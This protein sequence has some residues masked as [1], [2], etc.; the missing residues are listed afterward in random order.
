MY[1][2]LRPLNLHLQNA[3]LQ[4]TFHLVFTSC[5]ETIKIHIV[6]MEAQK[7]LKTPRVKS[8]IIFSKSKGLNSHTYLMTLSL[9]I[10]TYPEP[11]QYTYQV[12]DEL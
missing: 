11:I 10:T 7:N 8:L 12:F 3:L 4:F 9:L 6:P 5:E 1:M 2:A